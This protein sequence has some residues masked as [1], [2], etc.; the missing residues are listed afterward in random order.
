[1]DH[2]YSNSH[3][4]VNDAFKRFAAEHG[5]SGYRVEQLTSGRYRIIIQ[6]NAR[7]L[8]VSVRS[9]PS[10]RPHRHTAIPKFLHALREAS[11]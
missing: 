2:K 11:A 3:T 8:A 7:T 9:K 10:N 5:I 1:M 6:H 4:P